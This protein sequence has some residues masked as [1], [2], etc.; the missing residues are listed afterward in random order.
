[1]EKL[2]LPFSAIRSFE[3]VSRCQFRFTL[4]SHKATN[5]VWIRSAVMGLW[6]ATQ[7]SNVSTVGANQNV[8]AKTEEREGKQMRFLNLFVNYNSSLPLEG[9][10]TP[11]PAVTASCFVVCLL[12]KQESQSYQV[13]TGTKT[14]FPF[15]PHHPSLLPPHTDLWKIPSWSW[16]SPL[17]DLPELI[18]QTHLERFWGGFF[19][20]RSRCCY[21]L[22]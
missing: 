1:M 4:F 15:F 12:P 20:S 5:E 14:V 17:S 19:M 22:C 10:I 8:Q 9:L 6:A 2:H 7:S 21:N 3:S 18:I 11:S 13:E 16:S